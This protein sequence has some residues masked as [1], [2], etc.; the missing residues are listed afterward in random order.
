MVTADYELGKRLCAGPRGGF[1]L[2]VMPGKLFGTYMLSATLSY[3][4]ICKSSL[5]LGS[6]AALSNHSFF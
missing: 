4:T 5:S 1:P 6:V 2:M 3:L